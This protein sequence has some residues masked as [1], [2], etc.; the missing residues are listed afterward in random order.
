M[1]LKTPQFWQH[2]GWKSTLLWPLSRVYYIVYRL[3]QINSTSKLLPLPSIVIGNL[4]AGGA[5]KTPS[6]QAIIPLLKSLKMKPA[7][8]TRGYGAKLNA[9]IQ[10]DIKYHTASHVGDE[11][12]MLAQEHPVLIGS[13]RIQT[14]TRA[15]AAGYD[16]VVCDDGL[17]NIHFHA[18]INILVINGSFGLGN[19]MLLPAGPLR[20][21]F[22][23][24]L[25][26]A[27]AVLIIGKD[28]HNLHNAIHSHRSNLPIFQASIVANHADVVQLTKRPVVAFCG[29]ANPEKFKQT[30]LD[31]NLN[32]REF[33]SFNDHHPYR[34]KEIQ[35]IASHAQS[36]NANLVT[37]EKDLNRL[38]ANAWA[39]AFDISTL[40]ISLEFNSRQKQILTNFIQ[41]K[42][43]K[44]KL[45]H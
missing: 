29:I 30:L 25:A 3:R 32:I 38:Q 10:V 5:G 6:V 19:K 42:L 37:T 9:G 22:E 17:Q 34:K 13:N 44:A 16:I 2:F 24:G 31:Q 35:A 27:S 11:A 40:R 33:K 41:T 15:K 45:T 26:K 23:A 12:M 7:I 20:E 1:L 28:Q 4:T 14:A 43:A 18:H 21:P 36:L 39:S 8:L